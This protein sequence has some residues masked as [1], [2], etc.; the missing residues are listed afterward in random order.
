[1]FGNKPKDKE[2]M[3]MKKLSIIKRIVSIATAAVITVSLCGIVIPE[4]ADSPVQTMSATAA[5]FSYNKI[6]ELNLNKYIKQKFDYDA[7]YSVSLKSL[8]GFSDIGNVSR[9]Y[10]ELPGGN[11]CTLISIE[12][13]LKYYRYKKLGITSGHMADVVM[14]NKIEAMATKDHGYK[15][16]VGLDITQH[17]GTCRDAFLQN[18]F[19]SV[20]VNTFSKP[21]FLLTHNDL[22]RSEP[23]ILSSTA[24]YHS[25]VIYG[26]ASFGL[27]YRDC[28]GNIQNDTL[29][30]LYAF[31]PN[32]DEYLLDAENI[33]NCATDWEQVMYIK[34]CS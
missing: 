32:G 12:N 24:T 16:N 21:A 5:S 7:L 18:G 3:N 20:N 30:I 19:S 27:E 15:R 23:Y 14:Y 17:K 13:L 34:S 29:D 6:T 25:I 4:S 1:M 22:C 26:Y 33:T 28:I 8:R 31:D 9:L 11:N 10:N 2:I